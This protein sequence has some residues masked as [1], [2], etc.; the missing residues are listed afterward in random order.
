[1]N[2]DTSRGNTIKLEEFQKLPD[3]IIASGIISDSKDGI[4]ID[5]SGE[6][7]SYV[8]I[9]Y[10]NQDWAIYCLRTKTVEAMYTEEANKLIINTGIKV[11]SETYIKRV[12]N[13]SKMVMDLYTR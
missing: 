9:K 10:S 2:K 1:M 13:C 12:F 5:N 8:V 3:N 4:N 7:L 11:Q 6:L